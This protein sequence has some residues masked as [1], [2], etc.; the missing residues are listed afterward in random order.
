MLEATGGYEDEVLAACA[1]AGL[2]VARIDPRQARDFT[3]A[4]GQQAKTDAQDARMRAEMPPT[5]VVAGS[6]PCKV[7]PVGA[8]HPA[9]P[10]PA[11]PANR[12]RW[13]T[14]TRMT[15][16]MDLTASMGEGLHEAFAALLERHRGIVLKVAGTYCRD[17]DDRADLAQDIAAQLWRAYPG[18][19]PA[20][21]FSTWMY[22]IALNVAISFV[23][24][25][26]HRLR[27]AEGLE[28]SADEFADAADDPESALRLRTLQQVIARLAPMDR[29]LV[30]LYLDERS[31]RE[32]GEILG[33]SEGNVATK[34]SRIKQRI[35]DDFN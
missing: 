3:R 6:R 19:D 21:S 32:I 1:E 2:W 22:R 25:R 15:P 9:R 5:A 7:C 20:R 13:N 11:A 17:P 27:H 26:A 30:L 31:H 28:V 34:L 8:N 16:T 35:R 29:A 24:G 33:L 12:P 10:A 23:R 4:T 18:Y 14:H